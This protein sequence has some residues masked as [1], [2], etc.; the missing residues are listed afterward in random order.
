MKIHE[1]KILP[2]Y[3]TPVLQHKKNFEI[4]FN[5]RQFHVGDYIRLKEYNPD[6]KHYTG[7]SVDGL[8]TYITKFNQKKGYVVFSFELTTQN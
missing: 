1:L 2:E 3:F 6:T 5:D 8:I 7:R 4:R